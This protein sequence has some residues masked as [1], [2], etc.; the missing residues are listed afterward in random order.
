MP[1]YDYS[2]PKCGEVTNVWAG[3]NEMELKHDQCGSKMKRLISSSMIEPPWFDYVEENMG[4]DPVLI[5]SRQHRDRL[6]KELGLY[7]RTKNRWV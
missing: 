4:H 3:I 5:T 2:C 7:G 1:L 6:E